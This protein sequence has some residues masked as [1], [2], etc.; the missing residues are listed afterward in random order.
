M[1]AARNRALRQNEGEIAAFTDDDCVVDPDWLA[2]IAGAFEHH[3]EALGVQGKTVTER[4]AMTPFTRQIE[5]LEGGQP[6][7]TCNIAYRTEIVRELGGFDETLIRGEDVVLGQR[8]LERGPIIFAPEAVV[9]HPPRPKEWADRRAWRTLLESEAHFRRTYPQYLAARSPTLSLQ[10]A[11]HV[12]SRWL[13]LPVRR[14][15]RWHVA[16]LR[17]N[18]RDY[19]RHV[20]LILREKLALVSLLPFF[21]R[22]W[23]GGDRHRMSRGCSGVLHTPWFGRRDA[24]IQ[25]LAQLTGDKSR[26]PRRGELGRMQYAT[27]NAGGK[28]GDLPFVSVVVPTRSRADLLPGLLAALEMQDYPRFEVIVVDDASTDATTK[29]LAT[30]QGQNRTALRLETSGGSYAARNAGWH[31]A[32]GE[33]IAFTDDDCLPEPRWLSALVDALSQESVAAVQG[34]TVTD[35]RAVTPFTHEIEQTTPGPPYRTCNIAYRR[36]VLEA[37]GGFDDSLRWYADN[38]LGLHVAEK[39][40]IGFAPG[41]VVEHPPRPRVWRDREAWRARFAADAAHRRV[42]Q[43]LGHEPV[44]PAGALPVILWVLRPLVKQA[45]P[46]LRY[47]LQHP[48]L[49]AREV[50]PMIDEKRE[51]LVALWSPE[52]L[53][54]APFMGARRSEADP[55]PCAEATVRHPARQGQAWLEGQREAPTTGATTTDPAPLVSVVIVTEGQRDLGETMAAL[56]TQ[57]YPNREVLVVA[58]GGGVDDLPDSV[59]WIEVPAASNLGEARQAGVE[60]AHGEIIAFTDDDCLPDPGWLDAA[61]AA[62]RH[63]PSLWGVQGRTVAGSGPIGSHAVRV[64]EPDTLYQTCNIA[65]RRAALDRAGGFDGRF[66]RY[67]EDTALAARVLE[68]GRIGFAREMVVT[69]CAVPRRELDTACWLV[70]L[71]DEQLLS[72]EYPAFYRRHRGPNFTLTVLA[73]WLIGSPLKTLARELPRAKEDAP[74][75]AALARSLLA[76]RA[77]FL[78]AL[79]RVM[80]SSRL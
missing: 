50:G 72:R 38:I 24:G 68:D 21:I 40:S 14:Y 28:V 53:A 19:L 3:P 6:Y 54:V 73:R 37:Y 17:R 49:Y 9:C 35:R 62:F 18:P 7:R 27:T 25:K 34:A 78:P 15:W 26:D 20:P 66:T 70:L 8:V 33:I 4:S 64:P 58:H 32:R 46:H 52:T 12:V 47:L 42:L 31:T 57:S 22:R 11:E 77:G 71:E 16:Y 45:W 30:W 29:V 10:R 63:D 67:F 1:G 76:E 23:Y 69:H 48:V 36:A 55:Q 75:Y 44:V 60:A 13:L 74:A 5:Q 41:A 61:V 39:A 80:T 79:W 43:E 65:Y 2:A 59:R 51:L 56:N